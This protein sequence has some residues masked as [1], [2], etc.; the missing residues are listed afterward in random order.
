MISGRDSIRCVTGLQAIFYFVEGH[1]RLNF[2]LGELTEGNTRENEHIKGIVGFFKI[3]FQ[4]SF[5]SEITHKGVCNLFSK[6]SLS[7]CENI[8]F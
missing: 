6:T 4:S 1:G 2:S 8:L 5:A 3:K 7:S